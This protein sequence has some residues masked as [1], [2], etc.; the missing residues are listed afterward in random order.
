MNDRPLLRVAIV[1]ALVAAM[2]ALSA[3]SI[4]SCSSVS[5]QRI[6]INAPPY[7][8][9]TFQPL[10][11]YLVYRCGTID[12]HGSPGRNFRV[13]GCNGMRLDADASPACAPRE[14]PGGSLTTNAEY[15]AT[16]RSLVGL[17]PQVMT[18]VYAGCYGAGGEGGNAPYPPPE[19]C[20]PELLTVVEKAR[21]T[22][23]HKGGQLICIAPPCP[24]GVPPPD[25]TA[26]PPRYDPQDVCIVTWLEGNVNATECAIP[27]Q[28]MY[29]TAA[30]LDAGAT[31]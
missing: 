2:V 9:A 16:Y 6:G 13:W 29:G 12:C 3:L 22:E 19:S 30:A 15:L 5:N 4:A 18:T 26:N 27:A 31:E 8:E 10:G 7:S 21:G 1:S 24:P 28:D 14:D 11:D 25:P 20:H 17:E 23:K